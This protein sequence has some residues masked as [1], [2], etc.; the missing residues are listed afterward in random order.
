MQFWS[1][2]R[3][4]ALVDG[5][6]V[7]FLVFW[8]AVRRLDTARAAVALYYAAIAH[9]R[10]GIHPRRPVLD[11]VGGTGRERR[12]RIGWVDRRQSRSSATYL[13]TE[14]GGIGGRPVELVECAY[15]P[16]DPTSCGTT[17]AGDPSVA[18]AIV[19]GFGGNL[20]FADSF[21]PDVPVI[22]SNIEANTQAPSYFPSYS[23]RWIAGAR[24]ADRLL[25][26]DPG[27][28][29][30]MAVDDVR[31][32]AA[33]SVPDREVIGVAI[34][35][36]EPDAADLAQLIVDAGANT[37]GAL[38]VTNYSAVP[39]FCA[40]LEGA[41][42]LLG[43]SPI[44]ITTQCPPIDGWYMVGLGFN[45]S[46]PD[47]TD[48]AAALLAASAQYGERNPS[49]DL[50]GRYG[51]DLRPFADLLTAAKIINAAGG[52]DTDRATLRQALQDFT[53]PAILHG[54]MDCSLNTIDFVLPRSCVKSVDAYQ[55]VDGA[56][57][58]LEPVDIS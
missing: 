7:E 48:G 25:G 28:I 51:V 36:T 21:D 14:L 56:F 19:A 47:L 33:P 27:S 45:P 44:V 26:T 31:A 29:A 3:G 34:G 6:S 38:L 22:A 54:A 39:G 18:L 35:D 17:F 55:Y 8:Q 15:S 46:T 30:T 52:P 11:Y 9:G 12:L 32:L 20:E 24:L 13:N 5:P 1:E 40:N 57:V 58:T 42:D 23:A 16:S 41:L 4:D 49:D 10:G 50:A 37:A 2:R 53:G 43:I